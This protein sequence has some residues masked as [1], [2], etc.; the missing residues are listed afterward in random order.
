MSKV[1]TAQMREALEKADAALSLISNSCSDC[2]HKREMDALV[3]KA[4]EV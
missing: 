3:E 4:R 1:Y 2:K